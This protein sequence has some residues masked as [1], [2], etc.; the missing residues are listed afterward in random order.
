[1]TMV[2]TIIRIHCTNPRRD[3]QAELTIPLLCHCSMFSQ[4]GFETAAIW[5]SLFIY[6]HVYS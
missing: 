3:G 2:I 1:M 6:E 4:G 5:L